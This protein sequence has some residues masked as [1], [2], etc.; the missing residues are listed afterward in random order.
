MGLN[1]K[2]CGREARRV[3]S[4]SKFCDFSGK[5]KSENMHV[6]V[7]S[8]CFILPCVSMCCVMVLFVLGEDREIEKGRRVVIFSS[9]FSFFVFCHCFIFLFWEDS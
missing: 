8:F 1:C 6:S 5:K 9:N 7:I 4:V 3:V 2:G